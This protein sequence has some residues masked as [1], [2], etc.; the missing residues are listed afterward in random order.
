[1][2][3]MSTSN[4]LQKMKERNLSQIQGLNSKEKRYNL[5]SL[6][7]NHSSI[8]NTSRCNHNIRVR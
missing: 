8:A 5:N 7:S 6:S 2:K 3:K 4:L 1:M